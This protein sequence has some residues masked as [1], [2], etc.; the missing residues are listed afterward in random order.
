MGLRLDDH[1]W[2]EFRI[3]D[4]FEVDKGVYLPKSKISKG[5][6]PY[7]SAKSENNGVT[8]FIKNEALFEGNC[9]TIEKINF[10]AYYQPHDFYCSHDVSVIRND[11]LNKYNALFLGAMISRQGIKYSYGRQAQLNVVKSER[12]FLP[13]NEQS[14]PDYE[15]MEKY[16]KEKEAE[17]LTK[18][19]QH[20]MNSV[21]TI[22]RLG[23]VEAL[24]DKKWKEF[25]LNEIFTSIQRGKRL[26]KAD[27]TVGRIPY[28]SS[29]AA[30]NGV[31][32]F[33]GNNPRARIFSD[34]LTVANSGSVGATF[35]QP[36]TFI[37]SDHVTH[38]KNEEFSEGVY[39]FITTVLKRIGFKYSFNREI[40]NERI[41]REKIL[42][43]V[44][45]G[46]KPDFAYM[47]T[48]IKLHKQKLLEKYLKYK[49]Q[50]S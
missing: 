42:L 31:D 35:Y 19:K 27:H 20:A 8:S 12:V 30:N 6:T 5:M 17:G 40:N 36:F 32:A 18:Y 41:Q 46:G 1:K 21:L 24:E 11:H 22:G 7:I 48:Y 28:V 13:V 29:S 15:F 4:I 10:T 43:P 45:E 38:L 25:F 37:A 26:K 16:I 3:G 49:Y 9:I 34:C 39:A 23:Y 33:I 14:E 44:D 2:S 50:L 47:D